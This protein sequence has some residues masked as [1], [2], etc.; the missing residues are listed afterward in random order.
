M[1]RA[2]EWQNAHFVTKSSRYVRWC[3][4]GYD[5]T[6]MTVPPRS[7]GS[8]TAWDCAQAACPPS[9]PSSAPAAAAVRPA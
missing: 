4:K 3:S 7:L 5:E 9:S 6:S 8:I 2:V 1:A